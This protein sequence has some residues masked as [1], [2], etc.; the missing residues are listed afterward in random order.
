MALRPLNH[1]RSLALLYL[2]ASV[3]IELTFI[4]SWC[5]SCRTETASAQINNLNK[6]WQYSNVHLLRDILGKLEQDSLL[7]MD[8]KERASCFF[9][10][11]QMVSRI[12]R[13]RCSTLLDTPKSAE[14]EISKCKHPNMIKNT[15]FHF[16]EAT[17]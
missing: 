2:L 5:S 11:Q 7:W 13:I 16:E 4:W 1:G 8:G 9:P 10:E 14:F 17:Y 15:W 6:F 3:R 12:V